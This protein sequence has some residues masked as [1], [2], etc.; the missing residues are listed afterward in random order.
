[1]ALRPTYLALALFACSLAHAEEGMW[2]LNDFPSAKVE[3]R[4]GFAPSP[5]WL[6]R[7]RLGSVRL[8]GGCS[9]SFVSPQGLLMTNHHCIRGCVEDLS[10]PRA[11]LLQDGFVAMRPAQE[12]RCPGVEA[13]QLLEI[14]DVTQT[15]QAATAGKEAEA[16]ALAL[17]AVS[18]ELEGACAT[19]PD[20]R[21]DVVRLFHGGAYHL[22]RYRRFQDVRLAFAPEFSMA[23]F[24]GDPDNFN[25]PR[26]AFDAAFLR[27]YA[28]GRPAQTPHYLPWAT[29]PATEGDLVFVPG[30]PGGTERVQT[31]AQLAYQRD[32]AL[33]YHLLE[34]AELRGVLLEFQGTSAERFRLTRSR[35]RRVEN[36]LKALRG[37]HTY[38]ADPDFFARKLAEDRALHAK[39]QA[40]PRL[41][42]RFGAAWEGIERAVQAQRRLLWEHA[43]F[44]G[45]EA[46]RS[47][48]FGHARRLVRAAVE[49]P[50][51]SGERLREYS[52]ARL[53]SLEQAL[54]SAAP[55][56]LELEEKQLAFSLRRVRELLGADHPQVKEVLGRESPEAL[57]RTL[58]RGTRLTDPKVRERLYRGG[59]AALAQSQDPMIGLARRVD[60]AA[61]ALRAAW[62]TEVEG[63]LARNGELLNQ[64]HVATAGRG[65]YP[66]ATFTLR[67][68]YGQVKGWREGERDFPAITTVGGL[69]E[70]HTGAPPYAVERSWL[71]ARHRLPLDTPMNVVTTN[72]I[73]GGNSG[74]PLVDRQGR[75]AGLVFDGN[76]PSLAGRYG[77][78]PE[79]NRTVAVH[80]Q[81][82][83]AA[84][85]HVYRAQPLLAELRAA[86]Q[87]VEP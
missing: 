39:V 82:I 49:L 48:L 31:G 2:L 36:S 1:M 12:R 22:Y 35:L 77:Y 86:A 81:A 85:E 28:Q 70:R 30:H 32:R 52:A 26:Y 60:G 65:S 14:S 54:L 15:V 45:A 37:R 44:E 16:F 21:C 42:V 64:A 58:V 80:G 59:T 75:V 11:D 69:F 10:S 47:E 72:D 66:D 46:F 5:A 76:L 83:W 18:A 71:R 13:N 19:G 38:L 84:L 67:L 78:D 6:E 20:L 50:K 9:A 7:V 24:G 57:A 27:V 33:P 63:A 25:F 4:Y 29:R 55:I 8:A 51:P 41:N 3:D 68:S 56:P 74:S 43:Q 34:L 61:R 87:G 53:P 23:A 62:E 40:D 17:R 79:V 73:I